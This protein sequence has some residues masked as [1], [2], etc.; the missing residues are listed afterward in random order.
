MTV[1]GVC[2]LV[3]VFL[4]LGNGKFQ[5]RPE[6]DGHLALLTDWLLGH[7]GMDPQLSIIHQGTG[8]AGQVQVSR[9]VDLLGKP[10]LRRGGGAEGGVGGGGGA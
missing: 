6:P 4:L 5:R 10:H 3:C 2:V 7:R 1:C 8:E 9:Q